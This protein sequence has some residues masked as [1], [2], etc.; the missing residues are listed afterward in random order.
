MAKQASKTAIGVF[1]IS[2]MILLVI[3]VVMFGG[4]RYF[5]KTIPYVLFFEGAVNGLSVGAPVVFRGV[6]IGSVESIVLRADSETMAMAIPVIIGIDPDRIEVKGTTVQHTTHRLTQLIE[7]GLRAQLEMQSIVTGQLMIELDFHPE[8]PV[9]LVGS[10]LPYPEIPT[11]KSDFDRFAEK[12]QK[13]PITETFEK[14]YSTLSSIE[15]IL[16]SPGMTN[17]GTTLQATLTDL[18]KLVNDTNR[19][20]NNADRQIKPLAGSLKDATSDAQR[21]FNSIDEKIDPMASTLKQT[22]EH[23]QAALVQGERTLKT[24][25]KSTEEGSQMHSELMTSMKE[26]SSAAK[27]IRILADYI[28]QHPDSI[29]WGKE[30]DD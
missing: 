13:I 18:R 20:V 15:A 30:E 11:V 8:T 28:H 19:L 23:A 12:V 10:D 4:G 25:E 16:N 27:S 6:K 2:A 3:G 26:I 22:L 1:V 29:I 24:I 14:L 9:R 21:L 7:R 17:F 5:K